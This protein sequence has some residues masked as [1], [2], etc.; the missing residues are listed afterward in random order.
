MPR[1]RS[2]HLGASRLLP[3][4]RCPLPGQ[5]EVGW[6]GIRIQVR[7]IAGFALAQMAIAYCLIAQIGIFLHQGRGQLV[8]SLA[9][10]I[11][12]VR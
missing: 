10:I 8:W 9:D 2:Q 12:R 7:G 3:R 5:G 4:L 11:R 6:L 1:M